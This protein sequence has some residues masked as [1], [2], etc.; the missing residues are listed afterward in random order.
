MET[1]GFDIDGVVLDL[2]Y[3]LELMISKILY[4]RLLIKDLHY[5]AIQELLGVTRSFL[6]EKILDPI[7]A[8]EKLPAYPNAVYYL[9]ELQQEF[10][11][12]FV[13]ARPLEFKESTAKQLAHLGLGDIEILHKANKGKVVK[14]LGLVGFV[15]D[16]IKTILNIL[17]QSPKTKLYVLKRPWNILSLNLL[18]KFEMI[19]SWGNL[20]S[21]IRRDLL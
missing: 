12:I 4:K 3:S 9:Q 13:T 2:G 6:E 15:D 5:F 19:D 14:E 7:L 11:V 21:Q 8:M 20:Y 10:N 1:I 18:H 16:S 17:E